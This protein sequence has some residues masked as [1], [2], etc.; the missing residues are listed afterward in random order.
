MK[1]LKD[2]S[3]EELKQELENREKHDA[4]D[5]HQ[6][7]K[8]EL[9]VQAKIILEALRNYNEIRDEAS[10]SVYID[11]WALELELDK[12]GLRR[13]GDWNSSGCSFE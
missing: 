1:S 10:G 6:K 11:T 12:A 13:N 8:D 2:F 7:W 4:R 3:D 9:E 5:L